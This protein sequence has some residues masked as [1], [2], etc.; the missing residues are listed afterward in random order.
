M[1]NLK[2]FRLSSVQLMT[3][4]SVIV[5]IFIVPDLYAQCPMCKMA[6][7][8]NLKEGGTSGAGLN[9]GILYMLCMP[10]LLVGTIGFLWW[11][12]QRKKNMMAES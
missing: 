6:A 5:F 7:E 3:A 10:Y 2:I 9:A 11:R 12:A 1:D 4:L 8:S